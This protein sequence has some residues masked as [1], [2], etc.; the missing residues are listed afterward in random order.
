MW[1][2]TSRRRGR[3][4]WSKGRKGL[5]MKRR[6]VAWIEIAILSLI[7]SSTHRDFC[8]IA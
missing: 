3:G 7:V 4:I 8:H 1:R 6:A 5:K 2:V